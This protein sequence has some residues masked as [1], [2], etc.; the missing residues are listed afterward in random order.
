MIDIGRFRAAAVALAACWL[1]L[2]VG[3]SSRDVRGVDPVTPVGQREGILV[4]SWSPTTQPASA[5]WSGPRTRLYT[6]VLSGD[7]GGNDGDGASPARVRARKALGGL[8][9][10]VQA[11]QRAASIGEAAL[12][13][14]ANQ[15]VLP[16]RHYEAGVFGLEHYDFALGAGYLNR[17]RLVLDGPEFAPRLARLGPFLIASRKPLDELVIIG[18]FGAVVVDQA[19]PVL[20]VDMTESQP[21]AAAT[22]INEFKEAVRVTLPAET[23]TFDP[24]RAHFASALLKLGEALPF[25]AQSLA[26]TRRMLAPLPAARGAVQ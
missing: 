24:L 23:D 12:L 19:S 8:L 1:L 6:Y 2:Q 22:Y 26:S 17:F 18:P 5:P 21:Q 9:R 14:R 20:L 10:E 16:A 15:F 4:H 7:A 13:R 11:N 25:V 3:C